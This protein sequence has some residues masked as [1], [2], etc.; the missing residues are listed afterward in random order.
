MTAI[1]KREI[2]IYLKIQLK[3]GDPCVVLSFRSLPVDSGVTSRP[4][5]FKLTARTDNPKYPANSQVIPNHRM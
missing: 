4:I 3:Q 2:P 1:N 5:R